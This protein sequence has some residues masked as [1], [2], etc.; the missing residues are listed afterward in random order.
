M[1]YNYLYT[2]YVCTD[3]E[4]GGN[5]IQ[6]T[7]V[8]VY[9]KIFGVVLI[10][11]KLVI[12]MKQPLVFILCHWVIML[13]HSFQHLLINKTIK[14]IWII[15]TFTSSKMTSG[16]FTPDTVLYAEMIKKNIH[17]MK[18]VYNFDEQI[19]DIEHNFQQSKKVVKPQSVFPLN[20][21]LTSG[22]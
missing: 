1:I 11:K 7:C 13:L 9:Q 4:T 18:F 10:I 2:L 15:Q 12:C 20:P 14:S 8:P 3:K 16:P 19:I 21:I 17:D 6:W 22:I 5:D